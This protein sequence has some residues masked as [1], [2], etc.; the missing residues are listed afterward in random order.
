MTL[1]EIL[2]VKKDA[3]KKEI[4]K[5]YLKLSKIHHPDKGGDEE[6]FK[7]ISDAYNILSDLDMRKAYDEGGTLEKLKNDANA[8]MQKVF[9]IFE[10]TIQAHGFVPDH[11][12]LFKNM[13]GKCNEK[14]QRM[15]K[16]INTVEGEI[17]NI[18]SIQ[19]RLKNADLFVNYL[20]NSKEDR[21]YRIK[22]I[23]KE[24]DYLTQILNFIENCE[25]EIDEDEDF[26][27]PQRRMMPFGYKR[28][29][30]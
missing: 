10:E 27:P 21:K 15:N 11:T 5:A 22:K 23:E 29:D 13:R 25:Y 12:D 7:K 20:D 3:D 28:G 26:N 4:R 19:K 14:D 2:G 24:K 16:D 17:R 1:Y 30:W 18:E 6:E 9:S 8:L